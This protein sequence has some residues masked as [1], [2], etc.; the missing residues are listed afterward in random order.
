M[1]TEPLVLTGINGKVSVGGSDIDDTRNWRASLKADNKPY[2]S[3]ST[4]GYQKN[5]GGRKSGTVQFEIY[6]QSGSAVLDVVVGT[7]YD[8]IFYSDT[9]VAALTCEARVDSIDVGADIEGAELEG[10]TVNCT[11]NGEWTAA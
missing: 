10:A 2:A 11:I 6:M 4:A 9:A 5:K 7:L 1:A 8:F 3:S